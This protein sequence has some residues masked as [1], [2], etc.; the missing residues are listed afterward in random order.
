VNGKQQLWLRPLDTLQAES[1]P[2]TEG[3]TY[4][5][6]SPDNRWIGFFAQGR[7]K[8]ISVSGGPAQALCNAPNSRGG[9]WNRNDIIVFAPPDGG[10][11]FRRVAASGGDPADI[12]IGKGDYRHPTF[13]PDGRHFLYL[14]RNGLPE[15]GGIYVS[16]LDG[17]ENRRVLPDV[18]GVSG[19]VFAPPNTWRTRRSHPVHT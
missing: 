2:L 4:P 9:S 6:W 18:S 13:L 17:K 7:L 8:K 15:K 19:A 14:E 12:N 11:A 5:F 16:S 3:A 1:M 10:S